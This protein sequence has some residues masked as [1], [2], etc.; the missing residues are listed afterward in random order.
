MDGKLRITTDRLGLFVL[1]AKEKKFVL[2]G[3]DKNGAITIAD[4]MEACKVLARQSAGTAPTDEELAHGDL[5]KNG[6]ITI[7]DVMEICKMLA[8]QA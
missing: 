4:V 1:T 8:R 6:E 2:G 3:L 5:D 7:A